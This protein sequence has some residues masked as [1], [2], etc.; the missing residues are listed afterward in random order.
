MAVISISRYFDYFIVHLQFRDPN[1]GNQSIF[2][3]SFMK[4]G[5]ILALNS[6][7]CWNENQNY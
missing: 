1:K 5:R 7:I 2:N 4:N 6:N 3:D